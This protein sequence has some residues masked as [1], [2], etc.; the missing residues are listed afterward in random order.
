MLNSFIQNKLVVKLQKVEGKGSSLQKQFS[1][2]ALSRD[3]H[4]IQRFVA[5]SMRDAGYCEGS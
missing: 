1:I 2:L 5:A 4:R 3:Q